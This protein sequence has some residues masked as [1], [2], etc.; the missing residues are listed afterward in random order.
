MGTKPEGPNPGDRVRVEVR[1]LDPSGDGVA[2]TEDN[3][4]VF[5][6]GALPGDRGEALIIQRAARHARARLERLIEASPS[7]V[8]RRCEVADTCGGCPLM[9]LDYAA[10][11]AAKRRLVVDALERIGGFREAEALVRPVLGMERPW[12]YRNK[13]QYPVRR[14]QRGTVTVGFFRRGTHAVIDAPHCAIQH[15]TAV[16][17]ARAAKDAIVQIGLEPY[18]EATGRGAVRHLITRVAESTGEA[19]LVV[20]TAEE[21]PAETMQAFAHLVRARVSELVGLVQNV[22]PL[23]TNVI[24]GHSS[25]TEW[26]R[27]WVEERLGQLRLRLSDRAFFQVN[28]KQAV[29]LY[30]EVRDRVAR[31]CRC[32]DGSGAAPGVTLLDLYC[33]VG[34]IGLFCADLVERLV[35]VEDEGQAVV[36]A[37]HNADINGIAWA[38]FLAGRAED[39]TP[40]LVREAQRHGERFAVVVDPPRRGLDHSV[41]EALARAAPGLVVYVSCNPATL[42]RDTRQFLRRTLEQGIVYR[43]GNVQPVDMFP[44]TAHVEAVAHWI[45]GPAEGRDRG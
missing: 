45:R 40:R 36:D 13:G 16:R 7:R 44:H 17:L 35:G 30:S 4:V 10:Q 6:E 29:V 31:F 19:L 39:V 12:G 24:V 43:W 42:A 22:N 25:R 21:Q 32:S 38:H 34:T 37:R 15:P 1:A 14:D 2:R 8:E 28:T 18:D 23:R 41:V 33:G 20:V 27:G 3:F 9:G 11:L 26:G 5:V